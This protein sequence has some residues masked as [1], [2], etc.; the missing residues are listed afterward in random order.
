MSDKKISEYDV[1]IVTVLSGLLSA[2]PNGSSNHIWGLPPVKFPDDVAQEITGKEAKIEIDEEGN[3]KT[4]VV[5]GRPIFEDYKWV[6]DD[7]SPES[8]PE[9]DTQTS[10]HNE[11]SVDEKN[12]FQEFVKNLDEEDEPLIEQTEDNEMPN[13]QYEETKKYRSSSN[14]QNRSYGKYSRGSSRGYSR[15]GNYQ[16]SRKSSKRSYSDGSSNNGIRS[17]LSE[18]MRSA[19]QGNVVNMHFYT[20]L[21]IIYDSVD[22]KYKE[23]VMR[24]ANFAKD[25]LEGR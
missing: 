7:S 8:H 2:V 25:V 11:E 4:L 15:G 6:Y 17:L 24:F 22:D 16:S 12:N 13:N 21:Q 10:D 20:V 1:K 3:I 19:K 18:I 14:N 9:L 5:E 23:S